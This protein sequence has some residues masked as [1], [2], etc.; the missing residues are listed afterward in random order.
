MHSYSVAPAV[1]FCCILAVYPSHC[2]SH[3]CNICPIPLYTYL[4]IRLV[5]PAIVA[6]SVPFRCILAVYPSRCTS[7]CCNSC[8]IPLYTRLLVASIPHLIA[9]AIVATSTQSRCTGYPSHFIAPTFPFHS[10]APATIAPSIPFLCA[11]CPFYLCC[12]SHRCTIHPFLLLPPLL[13]QLIVSESLHSLHHPSPFCF[14]GCPPC[15]T[16]LSFTPFRCTT[17]TILL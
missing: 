10:V 5:A 17:H 13:H 7:H 8:P 2:T 4:S 3:C 15:C 9:S 1:P 6:T 12:T 16:S 11:S 14:G